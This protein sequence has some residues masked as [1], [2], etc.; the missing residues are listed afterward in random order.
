MKRILVT[1]ASGFIGRHALPELVQRSYEVH[2]VARRI[3]PL[4]G[5]RW[6]SADLLDASASDALVREIKPSHLLHLAWYAEPGKFW[7]SDLNRQ[8]VDA[9]AALL[10]SFCAN[11]GQI[12]VAAGTCAEYDWREG[13]CDEERTALVP[14]TEYGRCKNAARFQMKE[15]CQI[16]GISWSW[17]RIFH[18]YGPHEHPARFVPS[19]I[20]ALLADEDALCTSGHQVRDF[21]HV[22]DVAAAFVAMLDRP[23]A[24]ALNVGC[25]QPLSLAELA[26]RIATIIGRPE[27]LRLGARP[28]SPDDPPVLIPLIGRLSRDISWSPRYSLDVGLRDAIEWWAQEGRRGEAR[29]NRARI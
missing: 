16:A 10:R 27:R 2:A 24:G 12:A 13:I 5:V 26:Q 1:G 4:D 18:L 3:L 20:R 29:S 28:I 17:G 14:V 22:A 19:V 25:G 23:G 11:G 15:T 9:S 6:H 21:L 7:T 8:W